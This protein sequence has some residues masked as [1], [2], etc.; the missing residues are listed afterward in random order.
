MNQKARTKTSLAESAQQPS[1]SSAKTGNPVSQIATEACDS[2]PPVRS[3][4]DG[5]ALW[6]GCGS[7]GAE[8]YWIDIGAELEKRQGG[9]D[10]TVC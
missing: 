10:T 5:V 3:M 1:T 9:A 8:P 2:A 4:H 7:C 6:E